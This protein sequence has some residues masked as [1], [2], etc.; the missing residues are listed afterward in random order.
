MLVPVVIK[1]IHLSPS[2]LLLFIS[3]HEASFLGALP[4]PTTCMHTQP[5]MHMWNHS[6]NCACVYN[7][8][9]HAHIQPHIQLCRHIRIQLCTYV[10]THI[11]NLAAHACGYSHTSTHVGTH[12]CPHMWVLRGMQVHTHVSGHFQICTHVNMRAQLCTSGI[13]GSLL[14]TYLALKRRF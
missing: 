13:A 2:H 9:K 5:H 4:H 7:E 10:Y 12:T 14:V 1:S 6:H 3:K 11:Y 8:H